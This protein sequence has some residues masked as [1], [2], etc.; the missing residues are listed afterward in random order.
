[1]AGKKRDDRL[2]PYRRVRKP[3]PPPG[4]AIP[5]RRRKKLEEQTRREAEDERP[6]R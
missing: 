3:V 4:R 1:M 6:D 2:D 5:D